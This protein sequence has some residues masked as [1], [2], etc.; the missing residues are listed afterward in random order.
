[1]RPDRLFFAQEV[2]DGWLEGGQA[3]LEGDEL[4]HQAGPRF[5][6]TGGVVFRAEVGS[7]HDGLGL[8]GKVKTV[9]EVEALNGELVIGSA[10]IGDHAYEVTDGFLAEPL[11]AAHGGEIVRA[12]ARL[13]R[14]G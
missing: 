12:V 7:G 14:D 6:L 4:T 2:V 5:K 11:A 1:M 8:C 9:D 3:S 13:V 10:L